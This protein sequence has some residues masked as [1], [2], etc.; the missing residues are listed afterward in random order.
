MMNATEAC[1][2]AKANAEKIS[3]ENMESAIKNAIEEGKTRATINEVLSEAFAKELSERGFDVMVFNASGWTT[4]STVDFSEKC[5]GK[6]I[7]TDDP[8]RAG[9]QG[10]GMQF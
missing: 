7:F 5:T 9:R 8:K 4:S 3:R 6:I 10:G 2:M 1:K